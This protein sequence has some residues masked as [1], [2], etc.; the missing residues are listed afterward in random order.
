[1]IYTTTKQFITPDLNLLDFC[2]TLAPYIWGAFV[3]ALIVSI[4]FTNRVNLLK[5]LK[6][7]K[8]NIIKFINQFTG[9]K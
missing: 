2:Q 4:I 1:M 8:R 3:L 5:L 6:T 9:A 7:S